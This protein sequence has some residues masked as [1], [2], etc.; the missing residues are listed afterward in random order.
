MKREYVPIFKMLRDRQHIYYVE[1]KDK[2]YELQGGY[3]QAKRQAI[4]ILSKFNE[5]IFVD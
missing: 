3:E 4:E 5:N 2:I 1:Y